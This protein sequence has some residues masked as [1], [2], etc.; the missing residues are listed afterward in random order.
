ML[1]GHINVFIGIFKDLNGIC[2]E[3]PFKR[4]TK[5]RLSLG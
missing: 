3:R 4:Q 5:P 2:K 1:T